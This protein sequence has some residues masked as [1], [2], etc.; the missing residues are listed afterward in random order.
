MCGNAAYQH[1]KER[2]AYRFPCVA[3]RGLPTVIQHLCVYVHAFVCMCTC[4]YVHT[5]VYV[6]V[7]KP[8]CS[9]Y[10][11]ACIHTCTV[12]IIYTYIHTYIHTTIHTIYI[13]IHTQ[14]ICI[15]NIDI[16]IYIYIYIHVRGAYMSDWGPPVVIRY[17]GLIYVCMHDVYAYVRT[18]TLLTK[19][20]PLGQ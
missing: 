15:Y 6:C 4:V 14:Y 2:R 18:H 13:Y 1:S 9:F 11:C 19:G 17:R 20:F 16:Y 7:C 12:C 3:Y 5:Y 8:T 10:V